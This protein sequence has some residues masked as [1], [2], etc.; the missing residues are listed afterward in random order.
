MEI[1]YANKRKE[2]LWTCKLSLLREAFFQYY[3]ILNLSS[4]I[5]HSVILK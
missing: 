2:N 5:F 1:I 3:A 4:E